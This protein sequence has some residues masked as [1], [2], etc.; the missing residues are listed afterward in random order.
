MSQMAYVIRCARGGLCLSRDVD[1]TA[2]RFVMEVSP[3]L[4]MTSEFTGP[5]VDSEV[6][7]KKR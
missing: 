3:L 5:L 2:F 7:I 1:K 4:I 6:R